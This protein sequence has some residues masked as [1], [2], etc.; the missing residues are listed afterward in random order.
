MFDSYLWYIWIVFTDHL[1]AL[2][3]PLYINTDLI[4]PVYPFRSLMTATNPI[5]QE[6][7][8][9]AEKNKQIKEPN[10]NILYLLSFAILT[11]ILCINMELAKAT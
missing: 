1:F 2:S 6:W 3:F 10:L 11:V 9:P 8:E 5:Y 7:L 4:V